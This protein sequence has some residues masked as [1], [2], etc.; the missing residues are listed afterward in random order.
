LWAG[1][2]RSGGVVQDSVWNGIDTAQPMKPGHE[3]TDF[4]NN[5]DK[6]TIPY[7]K[8][9]LFASLLKSAEEA[10]AHSKGKRE[11]R[12]TVLPG[13]PKMMGA[14]DVRAL[15]ERVNVSQ[16]VFAHCLNVSTKL[17]QAW[18]ADRRRPDGAALRLLELAS[19]NPRVVFR[20]APVRTSKKKQARGNTT[21]AMSRESADSRQRAAKTTKAGRHS[22]ASA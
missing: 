16:A 17:V 21:A 8:S 11:L 2:A 5:S 22:T 13:L 4:S 15:R 7:M 20:T 10:L 18:E 14:E 19:D 9:E 12:T 1:S 3:L 6:F